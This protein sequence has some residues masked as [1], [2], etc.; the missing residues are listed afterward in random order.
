LERL[1]KNADL[2]RIQPT[3]DYRAFKIA[4]LTNGARGPRGIG[5]IAR[6]NVYPHIAGRTPLRLVD[7]AEY[8]GCSPL[9]D[10]R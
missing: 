6:F 10:S 8:D 9:I 3:L 2:G 7:G 1:V 4:I 5:V